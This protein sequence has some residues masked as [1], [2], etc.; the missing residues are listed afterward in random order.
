MAKSKA[1]QAQN[2]MGLQAPAAVKL[3][4][5][6]TYLWIKNGKNYRQMSLGTTNDWVEIKVGGDIPIP[7]GD[8][9]TPNLVYV[10]T[11]GDDGTGVRGVY[12]KPF[13]TPLA[14]QNAAKEGD[15][16][17]IFSGTYSDDTVGLGKDG[18]NWFF[19]KGAILHPSS[20]ANMWVDGVNWTYEVKGYGTFGDSAVVSGISSY[21]I[22]FNQSTSRI[23]FECEEIGH[24][25]DV[26]MI[27]LANGYTDLKVHG[28]ITNYN[29][30]NLGGVLR[31][32][33]NGE[34]NIEF[35]KVVTNV[36]GLGAFNVN[37]GT[38]FLMFGFTGV[39][40]LKGDME[41]Y[42]DGV[43]SMA[44]F[45]TGSTGEIFWEGDLTDFAK[46]ST[47]FSTAAIYFSSGI[48]EHKG[49]ITVPNGSAFYSTNSTASP[50]WKHLSGKYES[51]TGD[52]IRHHNAVNHI[53]EWDGFYEGGSASVYQVSGT[54]AGSDVSFGIKAQA[55]LSNTNGS[56]TINGITLSS[57]SSYQI[58][59]ALIVCNAAAGTK[60][61]INAGVATNLQINSKVVSNVDL[62]A[63]VTPLVAS[64]FDF[65]ALYQV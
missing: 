51:A 34:I 17:Y 55:T 56:G 62:N 28:N 59:N 9:G 39:L 29:T 44:Q 19:E 54:T 1:N 63:N 8:T 12:D 49:N 58:G 31:F 2:I 32:L 57:G 14:A 50:T 48:V 61:A 64:T 13:L 38:T 40:N 52:A 6:S 30:G 45:A 20:D 37:D 36:N 42:G 35:D 23:K 33:G 3:P 25:C 41:K 22:L 11:S 24:K 65:N 10:S 15:T 46:T 16:I 7:P 4:Y 60:N 47:A 18:V 27:E 43:G 21:M 5:W 53:Y 26:S